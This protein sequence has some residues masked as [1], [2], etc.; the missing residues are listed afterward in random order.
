MSA[1]RCVFFDRDNTLIVADAY[2]GDPSLVRLM[3][4]AAA[5]IAELRRDG[6]KVATV[7][8]QSGVARGMYTKTDVLMVDARMHELLLEEDAEAKIDAGLFCPHH[9]DVD[10]PYGIKCDCR[11]PAPGMLHLLAKELDVV[12]AE[13]WVVGDAPRDVEAGAAAGCRTILFDPPNV[14]RSPAADQSS[15]VTP[16]AT[17]TSMQQVYEIIRDQRV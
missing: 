17:A 14:T 2:L 12:L 13:S 16:T 3:P 11:K 6:Y 15:S 10:G 9:P 7:S 8:N 5:C 4:G 1:A